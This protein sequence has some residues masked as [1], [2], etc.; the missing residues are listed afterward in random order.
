NKIIIIAI[1]IMLVSVSCATE[2]N[3]LMVEAEDSSMV[4]L[5]G[6]WQIVNDNG[7]KI[8]QSSNSGDVL[9]YRFFGTEVSINAKKDANGGTAQIKIDGVYKGTIEFYSEQEKSARINIAED[10]ENKY[11]TLNVIVSNGYVYIDSII[12]G[13]PT[14]IPSLQPNF[15]EEYYI[16]ASYNRPWIFQDSKGTYWISM[17][18]QSLRRYGDIFITSSKDGINWEK[19]RQITTSINHDYDSALVQ[20]KNGEYWMVF[21]RIES[22]NGTAENIPY[23][24]HSKDGITWAEPHRMQIPQ[25]NAYYPFMLYDRSHRFVYAYASGAVEEGEYHDNIFIMTSQDG[26][27]WT[28]PLQITNNSMD[29]SYYPTIVQDNQGEYWLYFVSP[30]YQNKSIYLN[31]NDIF[32]MHSKDLLEWSAPQVVTDMNQTVAYNYLHPTYTNGTFYLAIMANP[33]GYEDAYILESKDG[34]HFTSPKEMVQ[35]AQNDTRIIDYKSMTVDQNGTLWMAYS[36]VE[37]NGVRHIYLIQSKDGRNWSDPL[38]VSPN[39]YF[40]SS[41][42]LEGEKS[43]KKTSGLHIAITGICII[44]VFFLLTRKKEKI[45]KI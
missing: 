45:E 29:S 37:P 7:H 43:Q 15:P 34:I 33:K 35:R 4:S 28:P 16:Q 23:I 1:L 9:S 2:S 38:K 20:D 11:H 17:E 13:S 27:T 44:I 10:L 24:T 6:A 12:T 41:Y 21:T 25:K 18:I 31:H 39:A 19:P 3:V 26:I 8:I 5:N 30:K 42:Q 40:N 36:K 14:G 32:V 22:I